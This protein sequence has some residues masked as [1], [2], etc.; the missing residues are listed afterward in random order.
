MDAG[1]NRD[2]VFGYIDSAAKAMLIDIREMVFQLFCVQMS[3]VEPYMI[4]TPDLHFIVNCTR[5]NVPWRKRSAVIIP[6][7]KILTAIFFR[8]APNPLSASV[9]R[10]EGLMFG[11]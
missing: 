11:S 2:H 4:I 10:N 6:V 8:I 7:H 3:A 5:Y 1:Y 9:I